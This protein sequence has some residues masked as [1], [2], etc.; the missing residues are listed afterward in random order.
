MKKILIIEDDPGY[1]K[2]L[3]TVLL[4]EGYAIDEA[5]DG[6]TGCEMCLK[7]H[8]DLVITDIFLPEQDG[9]QITHILKEELSSDIKIIAISG[10]CSGGR[11]KEVL[12]M[13]ERHGADITFQ[14]PFDIHDLVKSVKDLI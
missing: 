12:A 8:Y 4:K 13:S 10:G 3:K 6:K 7:K 9:V 2:M 1:R 11:L 5:Q 14:K